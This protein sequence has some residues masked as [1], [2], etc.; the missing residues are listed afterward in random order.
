MITIKEQAVTLDDAEAA[1]QYRLLQARAL[2][3]EA[4]FEPVSPDSDLYKPGT[5]WK[6]NR[7]ERET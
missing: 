5:E 7:N 2:L 1:E 6:E 3:E 4:G